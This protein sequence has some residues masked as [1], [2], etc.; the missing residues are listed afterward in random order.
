MRRCCECRKV[1]GFEGRRGLYLAVAALFTSWVMFL[2]WCAWP[3]FNLFLAFELINYLDFLIPPAEHALLDSRSCIPQNKTSHPNCKVLA[4]FMATM[5]HT[6]GPRTSF[7]CFLGLRPALTASKQLVRLAHHLTSD[8]H[9]SCIGLA[10]RI[11]GWQKKM[12][13]RNDVRGRRK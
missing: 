1:P 13:K 10:G 11:W 6:L 4:F 12:S 9:T 7:E 3:F 2:I 5:F 8:W